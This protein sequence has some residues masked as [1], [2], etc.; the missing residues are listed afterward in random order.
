MQLRLRSLLTNE[1][2][3]VGNLRTQTDA[4]GRMTTFEYDQL[5]RRTKRI[6]P[7]FGPGGYVLTEVYTYDKNSGN[8]LANEQTVQDFN[9]RVTR[10]V[11]D[12]LGRLR[13][14]IPDATGF[15]GA[16][17]VAFTYY[18]TG[19]RKQMTDA[20]GTIDYQYD[21]TR[22]L[23]TFEYDQLGRR[24]DT[25]SAHEFARVNQVKIIYKAGG[26]VWGFE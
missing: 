9:G 13:R 6:L 2:D 24:T 10:L 11:F 19:E 7:G 17:P 20:S 3:Q 8:Q 23:T 14:K 25:G 22:R 4:N 26:K 1:Y 5:G 18:P 21:I 16:A 12:A 15:P